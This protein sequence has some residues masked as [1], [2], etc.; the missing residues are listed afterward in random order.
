MIADALRN[1]ALDARIPLLDKSFSKVLKVAKVITT[2]LFEFF[3]KAEDFDLR[4]KKSLKF[5]G[6]ENVTAIN[7][8]TT[9]ELYYTTDT[10]LT[11]NPIAENAADLRDLSQVCDITFYDYDENNDTPDTYI[12]AVK[13]SMSDCGFTVCRES[14]CDAVSNDG[15]CE[16]GV[17]EDCALIGYQNCEC[18][19]V[20]GLEGEK[21]VMF[22]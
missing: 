13:A 15:E 6:T 5:V 3:V 11:T 2:K 21:F 12:E 4:A 8:T 16:I 14:S 7:T 1:K 20:V 19:I 18:D 10:D 17:D 9:F 22:S